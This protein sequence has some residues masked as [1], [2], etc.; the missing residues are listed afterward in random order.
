MSKSTSPINCVGKTTSSDKLQPAS[1]FCIAISFID[2][3]EQEK[4]LIN[5]M[6]E[7]MFR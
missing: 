7:G 4:E 1:S 2:I 5:K 6:A 3:G